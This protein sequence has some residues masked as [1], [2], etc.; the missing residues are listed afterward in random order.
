MGTEV[1]FHPDV[2]R[3]KNK[4]QNTQRFT[5]A[6]AECELLL[7]VKNGSHSSAGKLLR[8]NHLGN[9]PTNQANQQ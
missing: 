5:A 4:Q 9:K 6:Q 8:V 1:V 2:F 7:E 3:G